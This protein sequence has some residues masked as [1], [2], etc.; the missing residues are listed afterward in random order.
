MHHGLVM[1]T[2]AFV[3]ALILG[4]S[5]QVVE[6]EESSENCGESCADEESGDRARPRSSHDA[7]TEN[8]AD[9]GT[10]APA[11]RDAST[12]ERKRIY[13]NFEGA[14]LTKGLDD[15]AANRS[16]ILYINDRDSVTVPRFLASNPS[17]STML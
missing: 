6:E 11:G 10:F 17:R 13:L 15:A 12:A 1:R 2:L 9:G 14:T 3:V 5:C 8:A 16:G 4:A 7:S